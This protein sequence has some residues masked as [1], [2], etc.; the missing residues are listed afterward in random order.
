MSNP[1]Q[2][3]FERADAGRSQNERL[4]DYLRA[5]PGVWVGKPE[6]GRVMETMAVPSRINDC[7]RL[8]GMHID[9]RTRLNPATGRRESS[10]FYDPE[11]PG[12]FGC[13]RDKAEAAN[14]QGE[15]TPPEPR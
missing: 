6:L 3:E 10:Y 5:R 11:L 14:A 2:I 7:R 1:I 4:R 13:R 9:N 12:N 15:A 8:F